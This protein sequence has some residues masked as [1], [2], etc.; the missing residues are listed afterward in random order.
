MVGKTEVLAAPFTYK[1]QRCGP[2][3][4]RALRLEL[5]PLVQEKWSG[6]GARASLE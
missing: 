1:K 6:Q 2:G 3:S 4:V 5:C